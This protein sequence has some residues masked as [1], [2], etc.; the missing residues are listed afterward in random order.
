[1]GTTVNPFVTGVVKSIVSDT[2]ATIEGFVGL[3]TTS[4]GY[5][6]DTQLN[7]RTDGTSL[8]RPFDGGVEMTAGSSP[9]TTIVRQTRKYFRYQSGK[10]IQ[11]SM[12]I[13]FN[14][15]RLARS[16]SGSGT[17]VTIT[18]EYPHGL[19]TGDSIKVRGASDSA[20][21]GT[22]TLTGATTFT[23]SYTAGS[24]V[25]S[26]NPAGFIEYVING[27]NNAGIRAGLFD[28]Q[29]GFFFEYDGSD[30]YAVRR[31]SVQQLPGTVQVSNKSNIVVGTNTKFTKLL[32]C[33]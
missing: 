19:T 22:F 20:Y 16:A 1:M 21:N 6:V 24:S 3:D 27:Y 28:F 23:F 11:C 18:T 14:P 29:N 7:V 5:F 8:H 31:S 15:Y 26:T 2:T 9:D 25:T 13:N 32:N 17:A 4:T 12:A 33:W 30:L 10:G